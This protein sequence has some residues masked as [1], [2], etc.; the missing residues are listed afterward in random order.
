MPTYLFDQFGARRQSDPQGVIDEL[1]KQ[2]TRQAVEIHS[3]TEEVK[4][5]RAVGG[6]SKVPTK[7]SSPP[8]RSSGWVGNEKAHEY[9]SDIPPF[10]C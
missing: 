4:L 10:D 9:A 7:L 8:S 5:L 2:T 6:G 1:L 3:L